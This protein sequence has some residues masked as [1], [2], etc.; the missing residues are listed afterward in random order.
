MGLGCVA[1]EA[2]WPSRTSIAAMINGHFRNLNWRYLPFMW[3]L[4]K[5]ISQKIWKQLKT[6]ETWW[7]HVKH[8]GF[9]WLIFNWHQLALACNSHA[10]GRTKI[11][12]HSLGFRLQRPKQNYDSYALRSRSRC[13]GVF[14]RKMGLAT[15]SNSQDPQIQIKD[16]LKNCMLN[17]AICINMLQYCSSCQLLSLFMPLLILL[18]FLS[19]CH[20]PQP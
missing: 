19:R 18:D 12:L 10:R 1:T 15:A 5:G 4:C 3:G 8:I 17:F 20:M 9:D 16:L 7:K 2:A 6:C 14:K 13:F 11:S